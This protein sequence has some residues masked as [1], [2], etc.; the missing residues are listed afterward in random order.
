M[1]I[2]SLLPELCVNSILLADVPSLILKSPKPPPKMAELLNLRAVWLLIL[3]SLL[4]TVRPPF[5]LMVDAFRVEG[6]LPPPPGIYGA[7]LIV[8]TLILF[9]LMLIVLIEAAVIAFPL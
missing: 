1:I 3:T 5:T 9:V 6:M 7:L 2:E 8:L 4:V